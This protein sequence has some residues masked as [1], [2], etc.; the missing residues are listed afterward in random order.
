MTNDLRMP[1]AEWLFRMSEAD[2]PYQ[3][4]SLAVYA[5][6]FKVS[7]NDELA[8]L[9]GMDTKGLADKTYNKW[10]RLLCDT[11]WVII[12]SVTIGRST[13]IEIYPALNASPVTFTDA[14][15]RDPARFGQNKSYE[16]GEE[17][18]SES[19]GSTVKT[20]GED[21]KVTVGKVE[22]TADKKT[23]PAPARAVDINNI[24]NNINNLIQ[25][26]P[27]NLE[28]VAA[29]AR[30]DE[31]I[32]ASGEDHVGHGV[33]VNCETVR[34]RDFTISLKAIEYQLSGAL[35]MERIKAVAVGQAIQWA[36]EIEAGKPANK[37]IPDKPANFIRGS[38]QNQHRNDMLAEIKRDAAKPRGAKL[39][40][41][42]Q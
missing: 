3:A 22:I 5:V 38:L 16:R 28:Q 7:A 40:R 36:V 18:T 35:P 31:L 10:K 11:G 34:H 13:T 12:K 8:R 32:L 42:A 23:S 20:T 9:S 39:T 26:P 15:P 2:V 27:N 17:V 30:E 21:G 19:Y 37:V 24:Y 25:P 29:S 4:R 1:F 33:V 6:L 41:W 14:I